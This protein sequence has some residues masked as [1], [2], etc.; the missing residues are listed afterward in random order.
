MGCKIHIGAFFLSRVN[1]YENCIRY[2][3]AVLR[4]TL[5]PKVS[6]FVGVHRYHKP[7]V[8]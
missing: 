5:P 3:G 6:F 8:L 7:S 2:R 4:P 1:L